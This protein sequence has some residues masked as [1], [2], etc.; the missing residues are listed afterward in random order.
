MTREQSDRLF[1]LQNE[2]ED[3]Q[4]FITGLDDSSV[5]YR[6]SMEKIARLQNEIDELSKDFDK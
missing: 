6:N 3:E 5:V 4:F 2:I 1:E